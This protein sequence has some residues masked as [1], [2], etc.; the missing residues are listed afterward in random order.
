MAGT[1]VVISVTE[2]F[3]WNL[4]GADTPTNYPSSY[5]T[6]VYGSNDVGTIVGHVSAPSAYGGFKRVSGTFSEVTA[7][8][9]TDI[10]N[11]GRMVGM[12]LNGGTGAWYGVIW[13]ENGAD[14]DFIYPNADDTYPSGINESGYIVGCYVM[15]GDVWHGFLRAPNSTFTQINYPNASW[16]CPNGINE[17]GQIVGVYGDSEDSWHAY[18]D[19]RL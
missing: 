18:V 17:P 15:V 6:D 7:G 14:T 19:L 11:K 1:V 2:A 12:A 10:N 9:P 16:T 4:S 13:D 5:S 8:T 3:L